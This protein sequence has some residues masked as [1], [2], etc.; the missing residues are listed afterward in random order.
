MLL[1]AELFPKQLSFNKLEWE[2]YALEKFQECLK[3][4]S[5]GQAALKELKEA[6]NKFAKNLTAKTRTSK[7]TKRF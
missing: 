1:L 5:R 7:R 4:T 3:T 2:N 6:G